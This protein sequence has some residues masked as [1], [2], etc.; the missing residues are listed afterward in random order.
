MGRPDGPGARH[1]LRGA[2]VRRSPSVKQRNRAMRCEQRGLH[3][4]QRNRAVGNPNAWAVPDP[5]AI[6]N[7]GSVPDT[8]AVF[9]IYRDTDAG[10]DRHTAAVSN[11]P[12]DSDSSA[13]SDFQPDAD[14][15]IDGNSNGNRDPG[16]DRDAAADAHRDAYG[17]AKRYTDFDADSD[18]DARTSRA[19]PLC[20]RRRGGVRQRTEL[21]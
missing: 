12:G 15:W 19:G 17:R 10:T 4:L 13:V 3:G 6:F 20:R 16:T 9:N 11:C 7:A 1:R 14:R 21:E 2:C 18:R 5:W 8:R